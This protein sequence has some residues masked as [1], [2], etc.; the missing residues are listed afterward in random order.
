MCVDLAFF[1]LLLYLRSY[2]DRFRDGFPPVM[3]WALKA[4]RVARRPLSGYGK[5]PIFGPFPPYKEKTIFFWGGKIWIDFFLATAWQMLR[6]LELILC[7]I[8]SKY[9]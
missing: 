3:F 5:A 2:Y 9:R 7:D 6:A 4:F 1:E 8:T